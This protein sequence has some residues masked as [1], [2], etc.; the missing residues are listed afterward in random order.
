MTY[1]EACEEALQY[2]LGPGVEVVVE[3]QRHRDAS[4]ETSIEFGIRAERPSRDTGELIWIYN[5]KMLPL[6]CVTPTIIRLEIEN[7]WSGFWNHEMQEWMERAGE[8]VHQVH[9]DVL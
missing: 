9:Q 3:P 2:T 4:H 8:R 5:T 1:D 7:A 6:E